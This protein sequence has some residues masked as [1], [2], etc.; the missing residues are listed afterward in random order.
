MPTPESSDLTNRL[1]TVQTV[2]NGRAAASPFKLPTGLRAD[3]DADLTALRTADSDT[4]PAEGARAAAVVAKRAAL[5]ELARQHRGGHRGI[6]ALDETTITEGQRLQ[7]FE[8]Y[9]WES[10]EIGRLDDDTRLIALARQA[11]T[12]TA[13]DAGGNAAN[14]YAAARLARIAAQLAIIDAAESTASGADRQ[15]T[16]LRRDT[17]LNLAATTLL[18]VRFFYCSATRDADATP[19]LVRIGYQP[20]RDP[21]T[22]DP[23]SGGESSASGAS[24]SSGSSDSSD[25]ESSL[26]ESSSSSA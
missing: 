6:A 12:V 8:A 17:A 13:A 23:G 2:D 16:T 10:G 24:E 14:L 18:R 9:G 7:V 1:L 11:P 26:S 22:V 19:E 20:R 21:G 3:V 25:S 5:D 15:L 4:G